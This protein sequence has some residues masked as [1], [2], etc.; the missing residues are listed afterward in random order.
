MNAKPERA[1]EK[2]IMSIY[3]F[4]SYKHDE[5]FSKFSKKRRLG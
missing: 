1:N 3:D 5:M 4:Q 2:K